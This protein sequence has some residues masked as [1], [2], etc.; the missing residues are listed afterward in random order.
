MFVDY[1]AFSSK[2]CFVGLY[3][4]VPSPFVFQGAIMGNAESVCNVLTVKKETWS[5]KSLK[6][7][8]VQSQSSYRLLC[9]QQGQRY[10]TDQAITASIHCH[11]EVLLYTR[12][13][14]RRLCSL[15]TLLS[16]SP[17]SSWCSS[18]TLPCEAAAQCVASVHQCIHGWLLCRF[19]CLSLCY[20]CLFCVL[21]LSIGT[22]SNDDAAN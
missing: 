17:V 14:G 19:V 7:T 11:T 12:F 18:L 15:R 5:F 20:V 10:A 3:L 16:P 21:L 8:R 22:I 2:I 4:N 1:R 6:T 13:A 9:S